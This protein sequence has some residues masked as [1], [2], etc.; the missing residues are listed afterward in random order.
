MAKKVEKHLTQH[1]GTKEGFLKKATFDLCPDVLVGAGEERHP[2]ECF[3]MREQGMLEKVQL[4]FE[5]GMRNEP[6]EVGKALWRRRRLMFASH[7]F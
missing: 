3:R 5:G 7:K 1:R 4:V 6:T 2:D